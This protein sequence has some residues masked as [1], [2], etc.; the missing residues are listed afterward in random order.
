MTSSTAAPD[1][2]AASTVPSVEEAQ[3]DLEA[4]QAAFT[5]AQQA[6]QAAQQRAEQASQAA[7]NARTVAEQS[8]AR[9]ERARGESTAAAAA[10]ENARET[11]GR[12]AAHAY[13]NNSELTGLMQLGIA[14][15]DEFQ[16]RSTGVSEL[17]RVQDGVLAQA[18]ES[19]ANATD[20]AS[21]ADG[22][23]AAAAESAAA[24]TELAEQATAA[25]DDASAATAAASE[26]LQ[27]MRE[28]HAEA[29]RAAQE[30]E[31]AENQPDRGDRDEGSTEAPPP[32]G[33]GVF[34]RPSSGSVTSPYG[35]RVHPL[36]GVYK[37]HSGTDFGASC[38][39]PVYAAYPGTVESTGYEGA[40]GNRIEIAHGEIDGMDVTTTYNH[41]SAFSSSPGQTVAAG[42]L[43]GRVGTTGSSTGCHL[44]FEVL[45]NGEFTDPMAWLS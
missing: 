11:L 32:S 8:A 1:L 27:Q 12:L 13:M 10:A 23:A 19:R 6:E 20:A 37:L 24:A 42:D 36:T 30:R 40:Y 5:E 33:D 7:A 34:Q 15:P 29:E 2:R 9:A 43:I 45:V 17:M 21:R 3:A 4:A 31:E 44:H 41:L 14:D 39:S 16:A 26:Q 38:G 22:H 35:M 28:M 18:A 25:L